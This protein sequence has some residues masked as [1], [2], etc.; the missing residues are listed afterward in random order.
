MISVSFSVAA[1]IQEHIRQILDIIPDEL[2][3]LVDDLNVQLG[4]GEC[5]EGLLIEILAILQEY[6]D[7]T[8]NCLQLDSGKKRDKNELKKIS[9][10]L[11]LLAELNLQEQQNQIIRI[12]R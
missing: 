4:N 5:E 9:D 7:D 11:V 6:Y 8:I 10:L 3:P 2:R 1:E 12:G